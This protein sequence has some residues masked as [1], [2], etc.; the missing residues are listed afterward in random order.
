MNFSVT[1]LGCPL[2]DYAQEFFIDLDTGTSIDN[3]YVVN[4]ITH[5]LGPG[6]F[7]TSLELKLTR[8]TSSASAIDS[9]IRSLLSN[10][11]KKSQGA[12]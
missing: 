10:I 11:D 5:T 3:I 12:T 8:T 4:G 2:I 7:N 1:M 9:K 6:S